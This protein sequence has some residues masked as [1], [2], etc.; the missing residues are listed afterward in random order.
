[1]ANICDNYVMFINC[2]EQTKKDIISIFDGIKNIELSYDEI[3][4]YSELMSFSISDEQ[5]LTHKFGTKWIDVNDISECDDIIYISGTSAWSPF[6]GLS[7]MISKLFPQIT[8]EH[9]YSESGC[10]F[11]GK[12][13]M[14]SESYDDDCLS[15]LDYLQKYD[16][17]GFYYELDY[18]L[19]SIFDNDKEKMINYE[20]YA[21]YKDDIISIE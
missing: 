20:H 5:T 16:N 4:F 13:I 7:E 3:P 9:S 8:V 19:D 15:F 2:D 12:C 6:L 1:M 18:I 11:G 10:D 17:E 14:T 21:K